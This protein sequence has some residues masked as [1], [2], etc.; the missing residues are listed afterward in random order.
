MEIEYDKDIT[1]QFFFAMLGL[2]RKIAAELESISAA[3][4]IS[5]C[6]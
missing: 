5:K 2:Q 3:P 4:F 6:H 1:M